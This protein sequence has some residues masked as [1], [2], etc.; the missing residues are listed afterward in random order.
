MRCDRCGVTRTDPMA[1]CP[2]CGSAPTLELAGGVTGAAA[3]PAAPGP[4]SRFLPPGTVVGG[5]YRIASVIAEGGMGVVYRA[6]DL[7]LKRTVALKTLHANLLGNAD[8]RRRFRREGRLL[9][10]W[11]H[12]HVG[13]VHDLVDEPEVMGIVMECIE[14]PTLAEEI[15]RWQG[16]FPLTELRHV[17]RGVTA[18]LGAAH[19]RGIVHRDLKPGNVMLDR[20]SGSTVAKVIDFGIAKVLEGTTYTMTG[21]LLGTCRYMSPEQVRTPNEIGPRSDIYALGVTLFECLCGRPPFEDDNHFTVMMAHVSDAPPA[22]ADLRADLPAEVIAVIE[23]CLAKSPDDRPQSAQ[24]L[25]DRLDATLPQAPMPPIEPPP[26]TLAHAH[27]SLT[28][29]SAGSFPMGPERRP[30]HLRDVYV[31]QLPVTNA[32]FLRF[33]QAT[34]YRPGDGHASRFLAHWSEARPR[35]AQQDHPVVYVS[36]LDAVAYA[37]WAGLRLPTEAEWEK[38]ARGPEGRRYPWGRSPPTPAH[39]SYARRHH[40]TASVHASAAGCGPYGHLDL[41]GNVWEWC[42]DR[43]DPAFYSGGPD[44]DPWAG[45]PGEGHRAVVRGGAWGFDAAALRTTSRTSFTRSDRSDAIGFRCA[46]NVG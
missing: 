12:P 19:A 27:G 6:S 28:L 26:A 46:L 35:E 17:A 10:R 41:A 1:E 13:V 22:L 7:V 31:D 39:A 37:S 42:A 33:V 43:D 9:A 11:T 32:Q 23:S 40:G 3:R 24:D 21:A 16:R 5:S 25:W 2:S 8:I 44:H 30:V 4:P 34:G 15:G 14:G 29:V 45:P 36:W 38:T 20:T 18:G